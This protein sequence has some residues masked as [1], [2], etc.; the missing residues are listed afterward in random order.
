[1]NFN[2]DHPQ[3]FPGACYDL[4][5]GSGECAKT[6]SELLTYLYNLWNVVLVVQYDFFVYFGKYIVHQVALL[7]L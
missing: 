6:F 4:T 7:L 3:I 2:F 1:M 5:V